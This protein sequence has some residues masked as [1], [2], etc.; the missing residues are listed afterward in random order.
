MSSADYS[1]TN[2]LLEDL[3]R[4][5]SQVATSRGRSNLLAKLRA[6]PGMAALHP[7]A[8]R[9]HF[10]PRPARILDAASGEVAP[11][12]PSWVR[13]QIQAHDG[14]VHAVWDAFR[15][16][17]WVLTW[18][19]QEQH[20]FW[21]QRGALP[22]DGMQLQVRCEQEFAGGP[23]FGQERWSAPYDE[24][25][26]ASP[27]A[28]QALGAPLGP[29]RFT[30]EAAVDM[31]RFYR[32][33]Q[34]LRAEHMDRVAARRVWVEPG[35]GAPAYAS[36][37]R[38]ETPEAFRQPWRV[39]RWFEDWAYSSA[40]RSGAIAGHHW[41]FQ[42]SDWDPGNPR[43]GRHLDFVPLWTHKRKI[44][45]LSSRRLSDLVL[46]AWLQRLDERTGGVPFSWFFYL[47]HGNLVRD[48]A[49]KRMQAAVQNGSISLPD[50]D[51]RVLQ[52]WERA[53]YGF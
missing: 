31:E 22:W 36:T 10:S 45:P 26:L 18:I 29:L 24:S 7:S 8:M 21:S 42:L 48:G 47:L 1:L 30:L 43:M 17:D 11:S 5:C 52:A 33:G 3:A 28:P 44:A 27:A 49:G 6:A 51:E 15:G 16:K 38:R 50:H 53:P 37:M 39:Q 46:H 35:D 14:D 25:E 12:Y 2:A 23:L 13:E 20:Y 34:R 4:A 19:R 41:A 9:D 40:G 32:L